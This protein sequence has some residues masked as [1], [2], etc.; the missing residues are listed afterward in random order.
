[1]REA[2]T[3]LL[4]ELEVRNQTRS[5]P[6]QSAPT[7]SVTRDLDAV[8]P[9]AIRPSASENG[10]GFLSWMYSICM[11]RGA[12]PAA[13]AYLIHVQLPVAHGTV[14][15]I[16]LRGAKDLRPDLSVSSLPGV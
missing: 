11:W 16:Y 9:A 7:F 13:F 8:F 12:C 14:H 4:D 5:H 6:Y 2:V 1:M 3:E 15:H 10:M